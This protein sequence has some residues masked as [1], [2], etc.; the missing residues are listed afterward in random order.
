M[1]P[2]LQGEPFVV[3]QLETCFSVSLLGS[4]SVCQTSA[5]VEV[6]GPGISERDLR[7]PL[8]SVALACECANGGS[9]EV[10]LEDLAGASHWWGDFLQEVIL[11]L[12]SAELDQIRCR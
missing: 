4:S 10:L 3:G 6:P 12:K 9:A 1:R 5:T 11:T 7:G 8:C 2:E